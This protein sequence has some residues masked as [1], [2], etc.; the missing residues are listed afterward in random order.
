MRVLPLIAV[1]GLSAKAFRIDLS[2]KTWRERPV[3]K[4]IGMLNDMKTQLEAEAEADEEMYDKMTC[5]CDSNANEKSKSVADAEARI[6]QLTSLIEANTAKSA[7]LSTEVSTLQD[8]VAESTAA[9]QKATD[10]R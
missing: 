6:T 10:I 4:V 2:D 8:E 3:Q 7:T 5:Y 9:L 1:L